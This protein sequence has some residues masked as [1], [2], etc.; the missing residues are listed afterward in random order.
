M[1]ESRILLDKNVAIKIL[2]A[3]EKNAQGT[4]PNDEEQSAL[5]LLYTEFFA[6][7]RIFIVP[8]TDNILKKHYE[9]R[10][11]VAT[12]REHVEVILPARY[13]KRWARRL[14]RVGFTPEDARVLSYGTFGT[15]EEGSFL[16]IRE[17]LTFDK[18]MVNLF[19]EK[20]NQ[21]QDKL[22]AMKADIEQPYSEA[23]LPKIKL[24]SALFGKARK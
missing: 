11:E 19:E 17:V 8:E 13:Y 20:Q 14:K 16:G 22:D 5:E 21:I 15:D 10:I 2:H 6:G 7:K 9:D 4:V 18:P 1:S 24:L 12:F 23:K 3:L